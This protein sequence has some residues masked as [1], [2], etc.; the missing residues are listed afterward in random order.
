MN[1]ASDSDIQ[2]NEEDPSST[3]AVQWE[4]EDI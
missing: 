1:N 2:S 4:C 3:E